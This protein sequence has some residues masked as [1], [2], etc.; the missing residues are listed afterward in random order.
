MLEHLFGSKAR[1]KLLRLLLSHE[2]QSYY[3]RELVRLT[4]LQLNA[5]RREL[6]NLE[7]FG[8]VGS[9]QRSEMVEYKTQDGKKK[10]RPSKSK[11][12]KFFQ[13]NTE[14]T[15]YP[16]LK[17]LMLKAQLL[18]ENDL[19]AKIQKIG[20]VHF[21]V[22]TGIFVGTVG[23]QTDLLVVGVLPKDKLA[24][25]VKKFEQELNYEINYTLITPTEY[26]YRKSVT[27]RFIYGILENK[28]IV[29]VD[30]IN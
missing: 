11:Q 22:L 8:L 2:D 4:G 5:I 16:E 9:F 20:H 6:D 13:I 14:H 24:S 12:K 1:V 26:R 7:K 19:A 17:A 21:L 27:D 3:I 30:E 25:L 29:I 15:L 23:A 28:K 10:T 18:V